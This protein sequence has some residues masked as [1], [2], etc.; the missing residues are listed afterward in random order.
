MEEARGDQTNKKKN[1]TKC[2]LKRIQFPYGDHDLYI[3][4]T[5]NN[6]LSHMIAG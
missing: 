4:G 5:Q 1:P 3:R 6:T 2:V